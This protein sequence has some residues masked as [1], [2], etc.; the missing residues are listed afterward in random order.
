MALVGGRMLLERDTEF[1]LLHKLLRRAD[2]GAGHTVVISGEAGIG[3]SALARAFLRTAGGT[4]RILRGACEDLSIA[5][6]F[7]LASAVNKPIILLDGSD[8]LNEVRLDRWRK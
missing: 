3:K 6:Q 7:V 8:R 5:E 1:A 2:G 4:A